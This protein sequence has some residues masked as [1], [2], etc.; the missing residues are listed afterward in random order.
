METRH[1][2]GKGGLQSA[3][4]NQIRKG[5]SIPLLKSGRQFGPGRRRQLAFG[6]NKD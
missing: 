1:G 6:G 5:Q 4:R 2:I 3:V